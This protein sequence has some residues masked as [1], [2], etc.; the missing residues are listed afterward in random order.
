LR[1]TICSTKD[2]KEPRK[3]TLNG[4]EA[5]RIQEDFAKMRG[6]DAQACVEK[7]RFPSVI[8]QGFYDACKACGRSVA[9]LDL[10]IDVLTLWLT[11]AKIMR[12]MKPTDEDRRVFR[13]ACRMYRAKKVRVWGAG[14]WYDRLVGHALPTLMDKYYTLGALSQQSMEGNQHLTQIDLWTARVF[15]AAGRP[16]K[17]DILLG[18]ERWAEVLAE[19]RKAAMSPEQWMWEAAV[20]RFI[21]DHRQRGLIALAEKLQEEGEMIPA[22]DLWT[23]WKLYMAVAQIYVFICARARRRCA[24]PFMFHTPQRGVKH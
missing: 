11:V 6:L 20:W 4:H 12:K 14:C 1:Y 10:I 22:T 15:G 24:A 17:A 9:D 19:R 18:A 21:T 5:W 8:L 3:C 13:F 16:K 23:I 2:Q 7:G